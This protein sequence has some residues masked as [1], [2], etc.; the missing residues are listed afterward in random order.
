M[1]RGPSQGVAALLS[2]TEMAIPGLKKEG[3][4]SQSQAGIPRV[5]SD[6]G[7]LGSARPGSL[8][9]SNST[10]GEDP[11]QNKKAAVDAE[12]QDAIAALR[13]PNR[14][15]AGT[16][17]VEAAEKRVSGGLSQIRSKFVFQGEPVRTCKH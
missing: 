1:S 9:R 2:A 7:L 13:K 6:Y 16:A 10:A 8:S 15:L 14:H 12:L 3:S 17:M 4:E 11:K 5:K